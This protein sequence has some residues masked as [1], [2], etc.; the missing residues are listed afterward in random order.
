M[1]LAKHNLLEPT[2][3]NRIIAFLSLPIIKTSRS[4]A[5]SHFTYLRGIISSS[6]LCFY[7]FNISKWDNNI[8]DMN[9][10][11]CFK[12]YYSKQFSYKKQNFSSRESSCET[13]Q[14]SYVYDMMKGFT[15][16]KQS[17]FFMS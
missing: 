17:S 13:S 14:Y 10:A 8:Y 12:V 9:E 16:K 1:N 7:P 6:F 15:S 3:T 2:P 4:H 5:R 11:T